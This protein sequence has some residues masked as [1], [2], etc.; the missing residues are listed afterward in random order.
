MFLGLKLKVDMGT[1]LINAQLYQHMFR[2][3]IFLIQTRPDIAFIINMVSRFSH[4]LQVPHL[5][6]IEHFIQYIK[7]TFYLRICYW[8]RE[9]SILSGYLDA[10]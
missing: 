3:L 7:G 9:D 4:Q 1:P 5:E 8:Q 6:A 10:D 2:K